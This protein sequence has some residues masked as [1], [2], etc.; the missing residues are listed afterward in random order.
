MHCSLNMKVLP[1]NLLL[2]CTQCE[3]WPMAMVTDDGYRLTFKCPKCRSQEVYSVGVAGR[4]VPTSPAA[5]G[6]DHRG[7]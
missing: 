3:A 1:E 7:G 4:L 2:K 5:A 6:P